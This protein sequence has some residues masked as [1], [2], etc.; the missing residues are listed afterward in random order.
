MSVHSTVMFIKKEQKKWR[1]VSHTR[2]QGGGGAGDSGQLFRLLG[3]RVGLTGEVQCPP[4]ALETTRHG[5][6]LQQG[7]R[8]RP[9]P[10]AVPSLG[11][12]LSEDHFLVISHSI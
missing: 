10:V 6:G 3:K 2:E 5:P 1:K 11:C 4:E 12:A 8:D 7:Q 9:V